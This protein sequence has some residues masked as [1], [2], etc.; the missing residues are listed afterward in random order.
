MLWSTA[1]ARVVADPEL[2]R[3]L[4]EARRTHPESEVWLRLVAAAFAE[5]EDRGVWETAAPVPAAD[6]PARAPLLHRARFTVAPRA[7]RRWVRRLFALAAPG[8]EA[9]DPRRFDATALLEAAVCQDDARVDA[10]AGTAGDATTPALRVVAQLSVLPLLQAC[11]RKLASD[12]P[13]TW[14]E[15]YCPL[16]GAWP[17]LAEFR[18]LERKRWLRCGRCGTG[19]QLAWLR[20]PFCDETRHE[21]LGYLA[22]EE[23]EASRKAEVCHTC[24]GY[25]K[26]EATVRALR[27]WEVWLED[28]ATVPLDVAALDRGFHRPDRPAW[29]LDARVAER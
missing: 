19:W 29:S 15:G 6:R 20:C 3:R 14:W 13:A 2:S 21:Q 11:G 17:F 7:A 16:C 1:R 9:V 26:A 12:V 27:P 10:L 18:G 28:L 25:V 23:G 5:S 24:R 8:L 22:P 4:A